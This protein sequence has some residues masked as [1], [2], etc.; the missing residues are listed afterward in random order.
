[1][2][3]GPAREGERDEYKILYMAQ[4]NGRRK[5]GERKT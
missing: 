3:R 4:E 2:Q 5:C 1:M